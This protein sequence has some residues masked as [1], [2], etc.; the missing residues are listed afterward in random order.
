M[1]RFQT[2]NIIFSKCVLQLSIIKTLIGY[3]VENQMNELYYEQENLFYIQ[4][5]Q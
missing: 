5:F 2:N 1:T 3:R 4:L